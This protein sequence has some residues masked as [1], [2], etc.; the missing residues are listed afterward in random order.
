MIRLSN[1]KLEVENTE[2]LKE[3][4]NSAFTEINA[5]LKKDDNLIAS[6]LFDVDKKIEKLKKSRKKWATGGSA[7][8]N[9]SEKMLDLRNVGFEIS[10]LYVYHYM[11]TLSWGQYVFV[12]NFD[13]NA[14]ILSPFQLYK[15]DGQWYQ[16]FSD[17]IPEK[18]ADIH[19]N[20]SYKRIM[21]LKS[22]KR[23]EMSVGSKSMGSDMIWYAFE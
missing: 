21:R 19:K 9:N 7:N 3:D 14:Y 11:D 4:I 6:N 17:G 15:R 23:I 22:E 2:K 12:V 10:S 20:S 16:A 1:Y 5:E 18:V 8:Y 13:S